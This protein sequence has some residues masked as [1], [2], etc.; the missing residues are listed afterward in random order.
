VIEH[1]IV[2]CRFLPDPAQS[3]GELRFWHLLRYL[4]SRARSVTIFCEELGNRQLFPDLAVHPVSEL[5]EQAAAADLA[6]LEFWYMDRYIPTL[7][8]YAVP[9]ILDSVD[10]EFLRRAREQPLVGADGDY[11]HI[12]KAR[13]IDAYRGVDQVWAVSDADAAQIRDLNHDIVIAPNIFEAP[14]D[15]PPFVERD[16][17]CFVGSYSHQ[18]NVDG[19]RW[20]RDRIYPLVRDIPH[21]IIGNGA[22][23]DIR[24]MPGFIGGVKASADYVR[25]ARVSI[26][27]LRYGAGLKGKVLEAFA[28][29]TPVVTTAVGDEGYAAGRQEAAVVTDDPHT[30]AVAIRRLATDETAWSQMSRNTRALAARYT[31]QAVYPALDD[32]LRAVLSRRNRR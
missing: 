23:D 31:P 16:G 5:D 14:G 18:P 12:E 17:V 6:F 19:L 3:S 15:G 32:A 27:P 24:A 25:R 28:C 1:V 13:E 29:G 22:P 30:F 10:I 4:R 11:Y 7:R 20:Y 2:L 26:A 8:R 21:C 9:I